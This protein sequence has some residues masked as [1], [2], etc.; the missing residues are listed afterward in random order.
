M[1]IPS[2]EQRDRSN[3]LLSSYHHVL[4]TMWLDGKHNRHADRLVYTLL[5]DMH[6]YYETRCRS[7]ELGFS[8]LNLAQK[9][10]KEILMKN[11]EINADSIRALGDNCYY[12]QSATVPSHNYVVDLSKLSCDC[13][14][15]P[16]IKL[17]K[18]VSSVA[19]FFGSGNLLDQLATEGPAPAAVEP[20]EPGFPDAGDAGAPTNAA[21]TILENVITVS[22]K[23]L[24][25]G[26]PSS[27]GTLRSLHKVEAHLTAV[28]RS[29][30]SSE[31]PLLDKE[32]IPP[33]QHSWTET[34]Q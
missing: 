16:R 24:S 2:E 3:L 26:M 28:V 30:R 9:R 11:L 32:Q 4:K 15:W 25:G 13:P 7:Q 8:S 12:V 10:C 5:V 18:H 34:A 27:L 29:S 17:C 1:L 14:D 33:N 31:S 22:H 23:F 21:A 20:V 19:H 6:P